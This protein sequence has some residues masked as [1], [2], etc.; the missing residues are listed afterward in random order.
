MDEWRHWV[1]LRSRP[2]AGGYCIEAQALSCAAHF[3][4]PYK[5]KVGVIVGV[6]LSD[7]FDTAYRDVFE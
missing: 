5:A 6:I 2:T 3:D 4:Y 1:G 7:A